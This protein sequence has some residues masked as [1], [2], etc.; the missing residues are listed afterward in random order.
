MYSEQF[1]YKKIFLKV[2]NHI[3][4]LDNPTNYE[5]NAQ[6]IKIFKLGWVYIHGIDTPLM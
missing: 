5:L 4:W 2:K 3:D 1:E 6:V